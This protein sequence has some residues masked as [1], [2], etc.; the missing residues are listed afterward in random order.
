MDLLQET[1][2]P[3]GAQVKIFHLTPPEEDAS[4]I[5]RMGDY[6]FHSL[7]SDNYR[8]EAIDINAWRL[9]CLDSLAGRYGFSLIFRNFGNVLTEP[10][11]RRRGLMD[12]LLHCFS[13]DFA[14]G[15]ATFLCC[16]SG[17]PYAIRSY[18]RHGFR[19]LYGGE[20]GLMCLGKGDF[21]KEAARCYP[22]P[23]AVT[24]TRG[25]VVS[26]Y[27]LCPYPSSLTIVGILFG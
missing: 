25:F 24:T 5:R 1:T 17:T 14:A 22:G 6:L 11:W 15:S 7:G 13:Q 9:Y 19:M 16:G 21:F 3:D 23:G 2:Q 27:S 4:V 20:S 12:L 18:R 8:Q 26:I 10:E